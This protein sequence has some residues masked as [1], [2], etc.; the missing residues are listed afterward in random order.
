MKVALLLLS[1]LQN[2]LK[3]SDLPPQRILLNR[4]LCSENVVFLRQMVIAFDEFLSGLK[5]AI[6]DF[7][8]GANSFSTEHPLAFIWSRVSGHLAEC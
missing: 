2:S 3:K 1:G 8:L 6:T 5:P 4:Y 7:S